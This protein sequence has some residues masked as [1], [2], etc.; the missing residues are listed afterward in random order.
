MM[1]DEVAPFNGIADNRPPL[2]TE[3]EIAEISPEPDAKLFLNRLSPSLS[4]VLS[5]FVMFLE[6]EFRSR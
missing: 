1:G 3:A 5:R 6:S 4:A 2:S